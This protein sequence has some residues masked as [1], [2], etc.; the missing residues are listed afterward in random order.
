MGKVFQIL[1]FTFFL[2]LSYHT[3]AQQDRSSLENQRK[4]LNRQIESTAKNL[5]KTAL[6]RKQEAEKLAALQ[7]K[8]GLIH[9]KIIKTCIVNK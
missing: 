6:I 5:E 2:L 8:V 4:E 1:I 9:K 3:H 7:E